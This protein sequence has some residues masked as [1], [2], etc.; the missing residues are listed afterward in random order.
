M[1]PVV[2]RN[3]RGLSAISGLGGS[4][5]GE[6]DPRSIYDILDNPGDVPASQLFGGDVLVTQVLGD[7]YLELIAD[8]FRGFHVLVS[9]AGHALS[10]VRL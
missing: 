4:H 5:E 6:M 3:R 7:V 10:Q 9:R 1:N 2:R 8:F